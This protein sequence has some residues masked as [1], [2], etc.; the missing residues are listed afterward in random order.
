[1]QAQVGTLYNLCMDF[2]WYL[3]CLPG[4]FSPLCLYGW[5]TW[6]WF[7]PII[8]REWTYLPGCFSPLCL[9]GWSPWCWLI[10]LCTGDGYTYPGVSPLCAC[11]AGHLGAVNP[12]MYRGWICLPGCFAPMRLYGWSPWCWLT[13]LCIGDGHAYPGFSPLCACKAGPLR[14]VNPIKYWEWT[15]DIFT[16]VFLPSVPVWLVPLV[17]AV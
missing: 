10:L 16:R 5:A 12:I 14:L 3:C 15:V 17:L 7:N 2:V 9:Y 6:C 4:C 8:Y 1:M 11:I 13:L